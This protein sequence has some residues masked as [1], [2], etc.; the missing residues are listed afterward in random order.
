[1]RN[2]TKEDQSF[3]DIT[4]QGGT[5]VTLEIQKQKDKN[6]VSKVTQKKGGKVASLNDCLK[7]MKD[8]ELVGPV[9]VAQLE[10]TFSG[11]SSEIILIISTIK[12]NHREEIVIVTKQKSLR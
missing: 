4:Y 10:E 5:E 7:E 12:V 1:M 3:S 9:A 11:L 2:T 8:K 6:A